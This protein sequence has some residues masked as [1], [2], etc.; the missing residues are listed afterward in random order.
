M[1]LSAAA[2]IAAAVYRCQCVA[3]GPVSKITQERRSLMKTRTNVRL[4]CHV[5]RQRAGQQLMSVDYM[6]IH[7]HVTASVLAFF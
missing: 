7:Q 2:F 5:T 4:V 6:S 3:G 1:L